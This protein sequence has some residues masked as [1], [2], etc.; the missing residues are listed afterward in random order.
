MQLI[1]TH[2]H[3]HDSE[4]LERYDRGPDEL[5]QSA[6][7]NGVNTLVCVGTSLKSSQE[8]VDFCERREDCYCSL[9]MHPHEAA[10]KSVAVLREEFA[11]IA[12]IAQKST[13]K[14]VAIGETGLDYYYHKGENAR[15]KQEML[16]RWHIELALKLKLP[17][18]FHIRDSFD[19]FFRI[20]DEYDGITGVVHS[21]TAHE[22]EL[23][24]VINRGYYV[25]LNGI[26]TFTKDDMQLEA[27]KQVPLE[28]LL[29]ETDAPFLTPHPLRGT[30]NEPKHV[31]FITQFLSELR[32]ESQAILAKQ[33]TKNA[34]KLFQIN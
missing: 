9:A 21:F 19:D 8:A 17:L 23:E 24:G 31:T 16:F 14:L 20:V 1:D 3:I 13:K 7:N 2:C 27:A 25:G 15:K 18:I 33:T 29:L 4:F 11:Q 34:K 26:M 12:K 10:D 6:K 32:G 5:V 28:N 30:I 22:K